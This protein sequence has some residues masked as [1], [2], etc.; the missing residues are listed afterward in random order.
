MLH[1]L[2]IRFMHDQSG[3][4]AIEYGLIAGLVAVG[5]IAAMTAFGGSLSSLFGTVQ[6]RAGG[7][8]DAATGG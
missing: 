6:T 8:M 3:A 1:R 7:A 5:A 4:T 2:V